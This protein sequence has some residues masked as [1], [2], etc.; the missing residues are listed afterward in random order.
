MSSV[1]PFIGTKCLS[2]CVVFTFV[3]FNPKHT[4]TSIYY[5]LRGPFDQFS[6]QQK[7]KSCLITLSIANRKRRKKASFETTDGFVFTSNFSFQYYD[8]PFEWKHTWND[9]YK[10]IKCLYRVY[11]LPGFRSH[12]HHT[13]EVHVISA[14]PYDKSIFVKREMRNEKTFKK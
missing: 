6:E 13:V 8:V 7:R 9:K 2:L 12:R 4:W 3:R 10:I 5:R 14:L 1:I 11:V